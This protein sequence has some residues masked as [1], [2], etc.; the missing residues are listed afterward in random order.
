MQLPDVIRQRAE[1]PIR[2]ADA[3]TVATERRIGDTWAYGYPKALAAVLD[4][5][6]V[7]VGDF[8]QA[9]QWRSG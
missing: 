3:I 9:R 4:A 2:D 1:A 7:H 6:L 5:Y 8:V